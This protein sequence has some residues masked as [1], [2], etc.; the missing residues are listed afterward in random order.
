[1]EPESEQLPESPVSTHSRPKAADIIAYD[2]SESLIVSTHSRPKAAAGTADT[3]RTSKEFQHTA[4]R[5]RL[6]AQAELE[7]NSSVSTHS[8]PKAA[9]SNRRRNRILNQFQ[10]T[11]ARRRLFS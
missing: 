2:A 7:M 9:G 5:R 1:M 4:A 6:D 8:R 3:G 10:H 11:A